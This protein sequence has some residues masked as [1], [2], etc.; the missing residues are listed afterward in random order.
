M[1]ISRRKSIGDYE[2][3]CAVVF[4]NSG[5]RVGVRI[6]RDSYGHFV[7]SSIIRDARNVVVHLCN[8]VL[9]NTYRIKRKFSE[10]GRRSILGYHELSHGRHRSAFCD[11]R[12]N[13]RERIRLAPVFEL[14]GRFKVSV[15]RRER[16]GNY[17]S[18]SAVIIHNS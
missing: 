7:S 4:H 10:N 16:V 11:S 14:F 8:R 6:C 3:I 5:E 15:S 2:R 17:E 1:R 13:E 12:K 9:V 18:L